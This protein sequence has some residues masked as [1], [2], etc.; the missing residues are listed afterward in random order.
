MAELVRVQ[1]EFA[2][3]RHLSM[4]QPVPSPGVHPHLQLRRQ[5]LRLAGHHSLPVDGHR[6][7]RSSGVPPRRLASAPSASIH[8]RRAR[9]VAGISRRNLRAA[10]RPR[11]TRTSV[12]APACARSASIRGRERRLKPTMYR[13]NPGVIRSY[14]PSAGCWPPRNAG[15]PRAD[16][17][18]TGRPRE[19]GRGPRPVDWLCRV[20]CLPWRGDRR[21]R[22]RWWS[23]LSDDE[24]GE[25]L[26]RVDLAVPVCLGPAGASIQ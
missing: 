2:G 6:H 1:A 17:R 13:M 24:V 8:P 5:P 10:R 14:T 7:R 11:R 3:H 22:R 25:A 21:V 9:W 23:L 12:W 19:V 26:D 16:R 15:R 4:G 20:R 18:W